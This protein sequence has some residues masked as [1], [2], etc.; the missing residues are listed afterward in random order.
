MPLSLFVERFLVEPDSSPLGE[1]EFDDG[2]GYAITPD[3]QPAVLV[4]PVGETQT[5]TEVKNEAPDSDP[6]PDTTTF[7]FVD[8]E[9]R[10][11]AYSLAS[12]ETFTRVKNEAPDHSF[13]LASEETFTKVRTE[14]RDQFSDAAEAPFTRASWA[15]ASTMT[16][17]GVD[18]PRD[19]DSD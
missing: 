3:G 17:T 7:T 11:I 18:Y 13:A 8:T 1:W 4:S 6:E 2:K 14:G 12:S 19:D 5:V 10:D 15:P 16:R 9:G